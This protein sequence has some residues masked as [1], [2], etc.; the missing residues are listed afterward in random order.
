MQV[1]RKPSDNFTR[2][3]DVL[4]YQEAKYP[5]K[6][7]LNSSENGLWKSYSI[8]EIIQRVNH[9]SCWFIRN[10]FTR[11]QKIILAPVAGSPSWMIIDFACQQVGLV[12]VPIH[13]N[14]TAADFDLIIDRN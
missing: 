3:F 9:L 7:A 8:Q 2:L 11:G 1:T 12:T 10:G 14:S 6:K 13:A 5:N 4:A